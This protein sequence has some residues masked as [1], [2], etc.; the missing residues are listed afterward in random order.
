MVASYQ[1]QYGNEWPQIGRVKGLGADELMV[2]WFTGTT[3]SK[4]KRITVPVKGQRG[5]RRP[6]EGMLPRD[7]IILPPFQLTHGD[8]LPL[9]VIQS[10]KEKKAEFF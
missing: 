1:E 6:W 4:W 8:K 3:S 2:D 7:S 5:A 10:L 9:N